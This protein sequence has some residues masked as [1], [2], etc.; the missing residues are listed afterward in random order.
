M[1]TNDFKDA[2]DFARF[3]FNTLGQN[4]RYF[5]DDI[6][7]CIFW[8][9]NAWISIRILLNVVP[10]DPVTI[11]AALLQ[12]M[13]S[14]PNHYLNQWWLVYRRIYASLGLNELSWILE[15]IAQPPA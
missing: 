5:P 1:W 12:I 8:Y 3:K 13:W 15:G 9:E 7:K 6:L 14:A 4:G 11:I 2:Q 10:R